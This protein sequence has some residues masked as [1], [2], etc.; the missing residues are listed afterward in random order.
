MASSQLCVRIVSLLL[1]I[2]MV[3]SCNYTKHLTENQ[4]LL[5]ENKVEIKSDHKLK[6]KSALVSSAL[7]LTNPQPN[8]HL[9]DLGILPR[10]KLW[11]YN[12]NLHI[13]GKDSNHPKIL[14]RKVER[15]SLIDT[16][17]IKQS[18]D[19]LNRFMFNQGYFYNTVS[20]EIIPG[21]KNKTASVVYKIQTGKNYPI[22]SVQ[23]ETDKGYIQWVWEKVKDECILKPGED[24][25]RF[26]C[27]EERDRLY[28]HFRNAGLYDFKTDN[29]TFVID[30]IDRSRIK[31]LLDD[32][33]AQLF[34]APVA[35][36]STDSV[37]V[38][39][40]VTETRDS[41]YATVFSIN[42][43]QVEI[44]DNKN[45][46][47]TQPYIENVLD[48]I[49]FKYKNLPVNR[50]VIARNIFLQPGDYFN[51]RDLEAS[52]SRMNQLGVFQFINFR[53]EKD[54]VLADK[55]N[56]LI[57]LT[58]APK[59][60]L[61]L[62]SDIS[63][64]DGDYFLGLGGGITYKNKNLS[65][66]ANQFSI[67]ASYSTEFRNDDLLTGTKNFYQS[68]NN[69]S[70]TSNITFPKFIVPF[71]S[72]KLNKKNVPF[73]VLGLNYSFIQ[74]IQNYAIS[75]I[76]GTFGYNWKETDQKNWRLNPAFLTFTR[77][78][79]N[80][81]SEQFKRKLDSNS[82]LRNIFSNNI[83][84]GEN[85]TFEY[86]SKLKGEHNSFNSFKF[87][88]E[89]AGTILS[90]LNQL[91]QGLGGNGLNPIARY[92]R[93]DTDLRT[94]HNAKK[95]QW[96]NR[97]FIGA[98]IPL[99]ASRALPYIKQYSAGG[100]FS[101]RGWVART[102]GPGRSDIDAFRAGFAVI[103]RTGDMKFEGNSELRFKLLQL[104]SGAINF[105]GALFTDIGNVWLFNKDYNVEGGEF[106][107][108]Y[109]FNDLA[110]STG[111][112]LR[113]DF[114]FFVLRLDRGYRIKEP[115]PVQEGNGFVLK[116]L[117]LSN[118]LWNIGI[119]YPF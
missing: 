68:G 23:F 80:L 52:I 29:I 99:G 12:S 79:E 5:L 94:Y 33:F 58:M 74:R 11:R 45:D 37:D 86:I 13:Y 100:T 1:F 32:P 72:N 88:L 108:R 15:P 2:M 6:N 30:T 102:L 63:T 119:G 59:R 83:I 36:K 40:I 78:P 50:N 47:E 106:V 4:T 84:F 107:P 110:I 48:N 77:V 76:T 42:K 81:L 25:A 9:L 24:F 34:S 54:S 70:L 51:T 89:E 17:L 19:L 66:G 75:N 31:K 111:F 117:K 64:S 8:S 10:Y 116:D 114:S 118:G 7:T 112:G 39:I 82:Y 43:I 16:T 28:R 49:H 20:S 14:K 85:V 105:N 41:S 53:Y 60:D 92:I 113:F 62:L 57:V 65:H 73:T 98:G 38:R 69:L 115:S 44:I 91:V 26:R 97:I 67:K 27:G 101:N 35:R 22:R 90:G 93:F 46:V 21:R 103:D 61:V 55:L 104:F 109:F 71:N 56:C 18:E 87:N 95:L 3:M 96:V